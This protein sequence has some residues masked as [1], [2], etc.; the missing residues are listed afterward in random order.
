[1]K[2]EF[3][4]NIGF[5]IS[6]NLLIKP[7]YIFGIDRTVQNVVG[8]EIYGIY[9]ALLSLTYLFQII[10]DFGIQN[11]NNRNIAQY[12]QLLSKYFPNIILTKALLSIVYLCV[13]FVVAFLLGYDQ[14]RFEWLIFLSI[15]QILVS[16]IFYLRSNISGLGKYRTDSIV[17][18]LDKLLMILICSVLLWA[19]AFSQ[20]FRIEWFI[21]AQ[22]VSFLIAALVA[23][24]IIFPHLKRVNWQF[25]KEFLVLIIKK[26]YPYAF[27]IFLMGLYTRIDQV[28]IDRL[29]PDG[30]VETGIYAAAYRILDAS[31]MIGFLFAGLLLPMFAKMIKEK[32]NV[33]ELV[34]LSFRLIMLITVVVSA[35]CFFYRNELMDLM[36][37][38]AT[39]YWGDILG[40]LMFTFIAVGTS[41]IF[42]TLLTANASMRKL[43]IIAFAGVILNIVLNFVLITKFKAYGASVATL[44]TQSLVCIAQVWI[45]I[46]LF[47]MKIPSEMLAKLLIFVVL[48]LVIMYTSHQFL[49]LDWK[50]AIIIAT[51]LSLSLAIPL[52]LINRRLLLSYLK[53]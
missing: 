51:S 6:I 43:N 42:G 36:Y 20:N 13:I 10:N 52:G 17:S 18:V 5:L 47:K 27:V 7:F 26:S 49:P 31:N 30:A 40:I 15:N 25:K 16:F 21:Y 29:L 4:I 11:Y 3:L 41:Y 22:T 8:S 50:G 46:K 1:M 24:L 53:E 37:R 2:K 48:T 9:A 14:L 38:E 39:E 32:E 12:N 44:I 45:A 23:Y 19:P 35:A 28:M 33:E 34:W